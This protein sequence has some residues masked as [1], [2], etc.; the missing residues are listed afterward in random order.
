MSRLFM[1]RILRGSDSRCPALT[2]TLSVLTAVE[3]PAQHAMCPL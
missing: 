3:S 1:F 2:R